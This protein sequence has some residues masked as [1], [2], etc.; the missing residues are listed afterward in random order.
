MKHKRHSNHYT[1]ITLMFKKDTNKG[2]QKIY[3]TLYF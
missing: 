3:E 2:L 1:K